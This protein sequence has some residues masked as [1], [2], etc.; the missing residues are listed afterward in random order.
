[1]AGT[2]VKSADGSGFYVETEDGD[3]KP[4]EIPEG[5]V[6]VETRDGYE[7]IDRPSGAPEG[8]LI[9]DY[10]EFLRQK[11]PRSS[12]KFFEQ[13][14]ADLRDPLRAKQVMRRRDAI[15]RQIQKL[16]EE[17]V[18][19]GPNSGTMTVK[20]EEFMRLHRMY[21]EAQAKGEG[22]LCEFQPLATYQHKI[23]RARPILK[24]EVGVWM[25]RGENGILNAKIL[26]L[27]QGYGTG[28]FI[29]VPDKLERKEEEA[30]SEDV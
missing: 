9:R 3:F 30:N 19:P 21:Q 27:E 25:Q 12:D 7:L 26:V 4:L 28:N 8:V 29:Q 18:D 2:I 5:K 24:G 11:D 23:T 6:V 14:F 22:H 17:R 20:D 1:M 13:Q 15:Q 10:D 16:V